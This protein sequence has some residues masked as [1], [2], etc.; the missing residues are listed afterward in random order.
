MKDDIVS[1]KRL[2]NVKGISGL[3]GITYNART[4][5]RVGA[6]TRIAD[7]AD[8]ADVLKNYPALAAAAEEAA[9]PQIRHMATMG[10]NLCQRPRCWYFRSG[11]G[12]LA[13]HSGR[14]LV[15]DGDNRYHAILGNDGPA[16]FVSPSSMAP[17][18]IAAGARVQVLGPKGQRDVPLE[19]FFV[20]PKSE[21]ER[22]HDLRPNEMITEILI[23]PASA[24]M[25]QYEVRQKATFDWPLATATVALA[26]DGATVKNARIVLGHVAPIPW[27]SSEAQQSIIGK[28]I[29]EQ[30]AD[31]A[32]LAA[33]SR[34]K[35]LGR[36]GYKI[37]LTR[38]AVKRALL[39]AAKNSG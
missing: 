29:N 4:G 18:L 1:P 7:F 34:A 19:K 35:S 23:P 39:Q 31:A 30:T 6:L 38:V 32:G 8:H 14:S 20:I 13:Q 17:A 12:L 26:M 24:R 10:G 16:Y 11:L 36:N 5:L 22:E 37:Q 2:V 3:D 25:A 21:N 33:V 15:T 27:M 9:S 28:Q